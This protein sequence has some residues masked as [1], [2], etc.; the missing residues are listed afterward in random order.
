MKEHKYNTSD[1]KD[2]ITNIFMQNYNNLKENNN[3]SFT[4]MIYTRILININRVTNTYEKKNRYI[5]T[6]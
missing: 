6:K 2:I 1:W 4:L 3:L 5:K